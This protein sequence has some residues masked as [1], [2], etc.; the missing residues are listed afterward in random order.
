MYLEKIKNSSFLKYSLVSLLIHFYVF[1]GTYL[2]VEKLNLNSGVA[3][4]IILTSAYIV[5]YIMN[6]LLVFSSG[7]N[8]KNLK[9]YFIVII[10]FW[11]FNNLFFNFMVEV[12]GFYYVF[13]VIINIIFFSILRFVVFKK[14]V[15]KNY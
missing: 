6:V 12:L 5:S 13:V 10:I 3:Y 15:F 1:G 8:R 2:A 7:F 9:N 4:L 11:V 14:I